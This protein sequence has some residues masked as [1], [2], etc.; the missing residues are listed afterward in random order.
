MSLAQD[1]CQILGVF[2]G[3]EDG[4]GSGCEA[5]TYSCLDTG[6]QCDNLLPID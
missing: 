4:E 2:R 5:F 6:L 1:F 3:L